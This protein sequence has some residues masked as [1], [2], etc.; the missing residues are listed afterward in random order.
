MQATYLRQLLPNQSTLKFDHSL[1][2]NGHEIHQIQQAEG[3]LVY[4]TNDYEATLFFAGGGNVDTSV[5]YRI[6]VDTTRNHSDRQSQYFQGR[7]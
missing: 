1:G 2:I 6:E 4:T 7:R 5:I 3:N